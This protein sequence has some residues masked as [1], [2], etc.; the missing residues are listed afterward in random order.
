MR[1]A[2]R[3]GLDQRTALG[4]IAGLGAGSLVLALS[5]KT[6][7]DVWTNQQGGVLVALG[8]DRK[9]PVPGAWSCYRRVAGGDGRRRAGGRHRG[10]EA[11]GYLD[12][13][14]ARPVSRLS[15]LAGRVAVA[16]AVLVAAGLVIGLLT[17]VGASKVGADVRLA[18]LLAAGVNV[19]PAGLMLGVGMLVHGLAP[20]LAAPVAYGLVAWSFLVQVLGAILVAIGLAAAIGA[21]AFVRR[22]LQGAPDRGSA[23]TAWPAATTSHAAAPAPPPDPRPSEPSGRKPSAQHSAP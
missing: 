6:L 2:I 16:A 12:H 1:Q 20:S 8:G 23:G 18:T 7:Q 14:L 3:L 21:I 13:L 11:K 17:W 4:W 22:N 9:R 10:Q 5:A 19:I 15:W